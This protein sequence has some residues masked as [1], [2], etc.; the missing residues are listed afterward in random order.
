MKHHCP[1][2]ILLTFIVQMQE[3]ESSTPK[4]E[5]AIQQCTGQID[6]LKLELGVKT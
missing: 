6:K 5:V 3:L 4:A 2:K 1:W